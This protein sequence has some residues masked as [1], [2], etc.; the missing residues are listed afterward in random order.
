M[1]PE[2]ACVMCKHLALGVEDL[3]LTIQYLVF[4]AYPSDPNVLE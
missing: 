3:G 4:R 1:T 2:Y